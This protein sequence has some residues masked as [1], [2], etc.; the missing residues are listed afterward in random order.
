MS[1]PKPAYNTNVELTYEEAVTPLKSELYEL[2]AVGCQVL[3]E[4]GVGAF[5]DFREGVDLLLE[6]GLVGGVVVL[7]GV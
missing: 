3:R 2:N 6:A 7:D 5:D 4:V 1:I